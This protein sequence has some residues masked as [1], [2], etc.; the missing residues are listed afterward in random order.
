MPVSNLVLKF[1]M[2]ISAVVLHPVSDV[3]CFYIRNLCISTPKCSTRENEIRI[4]HTKC[5]NSQN[6][7]FV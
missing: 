2:V 5:Q 4:N 6:S 3:H 1:H 7:I